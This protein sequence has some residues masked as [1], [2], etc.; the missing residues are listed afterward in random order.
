LS[1]SRSDYHASDLSD[2]D[3]RTD[4]VA[5]EGHFVVVHGGSARA[6]RWATEEPMCGFAYFADMTLGIRELERVTLSNECEEP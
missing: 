5:L 6:P 4:V 3:S 1:R 2:G